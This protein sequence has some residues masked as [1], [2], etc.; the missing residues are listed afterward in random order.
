M[1]RACC[2]TGERDFHAVGCPTIAAHA[3]RAPIGMPRKVADAY[4][5]AVR[6]GRTGNFVL[7]LRAG[8]VLGISFEVKDSLTD[9]DRADVV[10]LT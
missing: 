2:A 4:A 9:V 10:A 6:A 3:W 8:Q 7:H 5:E 1:A